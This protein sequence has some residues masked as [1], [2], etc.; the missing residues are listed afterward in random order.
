VNILI[1][2]TNWI[3]DAVMSL[4]ALRAVRTRF[5]D[6]R[7]TVLA[8]PWVAALYEGE[9][10]IDDVIPLEGRWK[11]ILRL[12]AGRFDWGILFPN[13][14][15]SALV[16]RLGGVKRITGYAR[17]ARGFL[18][19]DA[20]PRPLPG[21]IPRHE[22]FYYLEMLRRA[23]VI[24]VLPDVPEIQLD[25]L[26]AKRRR[27]QQAFLAA[28]VSLPVIGVSPGAAY[29]G[30]KRWI[31]ERFSEAASRLAAQYGASVAVFGSAAEKALCDS[32]A[33]AAGGRS[34]AGET[35]LR[36]F[37]DMAAACHLFLTNDS[38]AMHIAAATGVPSITVFGPTDETAT[39]PLGDRA[40]RLRH[41]VECAPCMRRECPIDHRCMTRVTA[42]DVILAAAK[43]LPLGD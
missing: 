7:I 10:S 8:K 11:T 25:S 42:D 30:A 36:D 34:F 38:G 33:V 14:F 13:S 22:R 19:T 28:G 27:G 12:R 16:L 1:R 37:I 39:G 3:G 2:A 17:D 35:S 29:G 21:Q 43:I 9:R 26:D 32:V 31:P 6:A 18:L 5:P 15:D 4:P 24:D 23:G 20:I 41:P 40:V